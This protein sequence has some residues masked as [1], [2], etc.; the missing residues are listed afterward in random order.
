MRREPGRKTA[1][2]EGGLK[3]QGF[4]LGKN[5]L[6]EE[7]VNDQLKERGEKRTLFR[8]RYTLLETYRQDMDVTFVVRPNHFAKYGMRMYTSQDHQT[9]K[10]I[11]HRCRSCT[12]EDSKNFLMV[13]ESFEAQSVLYT[14][15]HFVDLTLEQIISYNEEPTSSVNH[16]HLASI[17]RQ[18]CY[19]TLRDKL[20]I[21]TAGRF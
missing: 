21:L 9:I 16:F 5:N 20:F 3:Q 1:W 18:V 8:G 19:P 13:V 2:F 6:G 11:I 10:H 7:V 14:I 12:L 4:L 17:L 15:S